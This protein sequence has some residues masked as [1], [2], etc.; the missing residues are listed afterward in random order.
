MTNPSSASEPF[1]ILGCVRSGTTML[2]DLLRSVPGLYCPEETHFYRWGHP[3]GTQQ[4]Q[5]QYLKNKVLANHRDIDGLTEQ[6][7]VDLF[8]RARSR[9]EF[10][11]GYM[12][13]FREAQGIPADHRWFDKTPQNLFGL[14]LLHADFPG[15]RFVHLYRDPR[16]IVASLKVGKVMSL[17]DPVAASN[18]WRESEL[19][20]ADFDR[21]HP[22]A[23]LTL[24]YA[25]LTRNPTAE[26]AKITDFLGIDPVPDSAAAEVRPE[27]RSFEEVLT[28]AELR[29]VEEIC[30]PV[31]EQLG[32]H[33]D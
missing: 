19:I 12:E 2:R 15:S 22:G 1:F 25:E 10:A 11:V 3:Y 28:L 14:L 29:V 9:R 26:L 7:V 33:F 18:Y 30:N 8:D 4:F 6:Q 21:T 16:N 31:A 24:S 32:Y 20:T 17:P 5:N 23:M 13:L 27:R